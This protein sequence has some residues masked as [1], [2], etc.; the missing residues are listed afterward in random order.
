MDPA[1]KLATFQDLMSLPDDVRAEVI[2]GSIVALPRPL[3]RHSNVQRSLGS[4]IGKPFHDDDGFGGP[5]G[6]WILLEV[7]VQLGAHLVVQPDLAGWRRERL[8]D[9]WDKRPIDV[10]PD[11][12]CEVLSPS[13]AAHDR[14]TKR[15]LYAEHGVPFYWIID[16]A[17]GT[18]EALRLDHGVWVEVAV[19]DAT[20]VAR[21]PPFEAIELPVGR[22]F[23]PP[24][25]PPAER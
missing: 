23:P 18:L 2:H 1:R 11:W 24:P 20:D 12:V 14:V 7:A 25:A 8:P 6:W 16:P 3:P 22:L 10:M 4:F 15:R 5:G 21:V 17:D 9:P 13:N 19:L